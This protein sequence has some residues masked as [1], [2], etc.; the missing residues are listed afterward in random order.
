MPVYACICAAVTTSQVEAT[1]LAGARTVS[2]IGERCFAGTGCGNCV[3][4]LEELIEQSEPS[5]ESVE[6]LPQSA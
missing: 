1:I 2:D 5:S 3:D 4:R 6:K